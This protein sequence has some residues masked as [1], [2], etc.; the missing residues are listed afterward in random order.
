ML[1]SSKT[2]KKDVTCD[3]DAASDRFVKASFAS[4]IRKYD[5][6]ILWLK[7]LDQSLG[8]SS[9]LKETIS[10]SLCKRDC[11]VAHVK[12]NCR[13]DPICVF[14]GKPTSK[15]LLAK[16][17]VVVILNTFWLCRY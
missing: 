12:C 16:L 2:P 17:A 10:C 8:I 6:A 5:N 3:A 15:Y 11:Y 4:L 1:N 13:P 9:N 14:H 7:S